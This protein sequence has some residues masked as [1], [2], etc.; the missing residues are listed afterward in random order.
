[1]DADVV[2]LDPQRYL[3]DPSKSLSAV[4]WSSFEGMELRVKVVATFSRGRLVY[5]RG[6]VVNTP[7]HGRFLRPVKPPSADIHAH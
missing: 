6:A 4:T 1:M 3:F 2:V 5:D 7:G